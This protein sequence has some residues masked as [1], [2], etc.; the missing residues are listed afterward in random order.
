M[1][2]NTKQTRADY[3]LGVVIREA[4]QHDERL[5]ADSIDVTVVDGLATLS[6][7]VQSYRRKLLAIETAESIRGCR[8]TVDELSVEPPGPLTDE[9]VGN[10]VRAALDAH[11]DV[12]REVIT[13][14][15]KGGV[16]T[17]NGHVASRW[18]RELAGDIALGARGVRE[19]NNLLLVDLAGKIEDEALTRTIQYALSRTSGLEGCD[20]QVA[21][22]SSTA[23]LSGTVTEPWHRRKAESVVDRYRVTDIRN[24]I[25]VDGR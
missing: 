8:G 18:E 4:L 22:N 21:V 1:A 25:I 3:E 16:A 12:T 20:V 11:A 2:L 15:V 13:V 23:V 7:V 24:E 19:V 5:S 14:I 10:N 17:L 6:G 9:Q